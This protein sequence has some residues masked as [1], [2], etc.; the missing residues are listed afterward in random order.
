MIGHLFAI[1]DT[2]YISWTPRSVRDGQL[3]EAWSYYLDQ[4][5]RR[6]KGGMALM[7]SIVS[8]RGPA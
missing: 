7:A 4:L 8:V 3:D 5:N 6:S 2:G 1:G